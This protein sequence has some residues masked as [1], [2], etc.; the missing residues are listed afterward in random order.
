MPRFSTVFK[1]D[2]ANNL[3]FLVGQIPV[4]LHSYCVVHVLLL[5]LVIL[6]STCI[7]IEIGNTV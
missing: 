5:R 4:A 2:R 1:L 3:L 7:V 6:C